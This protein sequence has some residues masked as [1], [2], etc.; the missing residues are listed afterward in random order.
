MDDSCR[1]DQRPEGNTA[2]F[3]RTGRAICRGYD[4]LPFQMSKTSPVLEG[5]GGG[6]HGPMVSA[7][8]CTNADNLD[9]I[10]IYNKSRAF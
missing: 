10:P 4:L 5:A 2:L 9:K 7:V 1:H 3:H 6:G 8:E